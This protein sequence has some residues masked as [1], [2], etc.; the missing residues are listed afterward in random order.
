MLNA[1]LVR[2]GQPFPPAT[3]DELDILPGVPE[4]LHKLHHAGFLLL[5]CTNQPDIARGKTKLADVQKIHAHMMQ[6]L[7][8]DDVFMCPHDG[9]DGCACRKPKPGMIVQGAEKWGVD[10]RQSFMVG[11]RWRDVAAGQAA[12]CTN[13]FINYNYNES[14][15]QPPFFEVASLLE[16]ADHILSNPVT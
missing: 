11:D 5:V 7:P 4:A 2:D 6:T 12:G 3:L 15:P 10:P 9:G 13:Y 14:Q 8:L 16:A 1:S